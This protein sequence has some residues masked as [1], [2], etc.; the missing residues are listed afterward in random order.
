MHPA[1]L[2]DVPIRIS[3]ALLDKRVRALFTDAFKNQLNELNCPGNTVAYVPYSLV[4]PTTG[5]FAGL[6][7]HFGLL[8]TDRLRLVGSPLSVV[9][10]SMLCRCCYT[11]S[12]PQ[13]EAVNYRRFLTTI[14]KGG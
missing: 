10:A 5:K 6:S 11:G 9:V 1:L 8:D 7:V 12:Y 4:A 13:E 3:Q 2:I 14:L